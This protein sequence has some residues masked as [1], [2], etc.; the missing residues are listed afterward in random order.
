MNTPTR[1]IANSRLLI[2]VAA[3]V[4]LLVIAAVYLPD[5]GRGFVKDDFGW[6]RD[7]RTGLVEPGRIV[8]LS[9]PGFYRPLVTAAFVVDY[10][11]YG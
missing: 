1:P 11:L 8:Q 7:A 9:H 5:I 10:V 2:V 4:M 3:A 6:I